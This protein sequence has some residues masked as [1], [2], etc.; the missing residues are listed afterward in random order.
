MF[1]Y[2]LVRAISFPTFV[3]GRMVELIQQKRRKEM[4]KRFAVALCFLALVLNCANADVMKEVGI[5]KI[6]KDIKARYPKEFTFNYEELLKKYSE[7]S[8]GKIFN[9]APDGFLQIVPVGP[10]EM[11]VVALPN[12][13]FL[14]VYHLEKGGVAYK[15]KVLQYDEIHGVNG[16]MFSKETGTGYDAGEYGP[17][18]EFG[19]ALEAAQQTGKVSLFIKRKYYSKKKKSASPKEKSKKIFLEIEKLGRFN[20][21]YPYKCKKSKFLADE[22]A[23]QIAEQLNGKRFARFDPLLALA[24]LSHGDPKHL[25]ALENVAQRCLPAKDQMEWNKPLRLSSERIH[26]SWDNGFRLVFLTEYFYATGDTRVIP[27]IQSLVYTVPTYHQN[28][29]GGFGHGGGNGS[30][31]GI[32]FGPSGGMNLT[33]VA[34]AHRMGL[35]VD[36]SAYSMYYNML[37]GRVNRQLAGKPDKLNFDSKKYY[38]VGYSH[39]LSGPKD[40]RHIGES[41][42]NT[43]TAILALDT[44][45][46]IEE[47]KAIALRMRDT[48]A[49]SP[50]LFTYIHATPGLGQFWATLAMSATDKTGE[51][52]KCQMEYRKYWL[53]YSRFPNKEWVYVYPKY[54]RN[55]LPVGGGWGGDGYLNMSK[56]QLGQ[57]LLMLSITNRNLCL[58]GNKKRNWMKPQVSVKETKTFLSSYHKKYA[59][60]AC[61]LKGKEL[62]EAVKLE[63]KKKHDDALF[64]YVA[65]HNSLEMLYDNY[66]ATPS[67]SKLKALL[68]K[69]KSKL[70][71]GSSKRLDYKLKQVEYALKK[72]YAQHGHERA[73]R[74][75]FDKTKAKLVG[76]LEEA[77]KKYKLPENYLESYAKSRGMKKKLN[78]E[79][80]D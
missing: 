39:I 15:G 25:P 6:V 10:L 65:L 57:C 26:G 22:L 14:I 16:K 63:K 44:M 50:Q 32:T 40:K 45:P 59:E 77:F 41:A 37:T 54:A 19:D 51:N 20:K 17:V 55:T 33:G 35:K 43:S 18:K 34:L 7:E 60:E 47:S 67:G 70:A 69:T 66:K 4:G 75:G 38:T 80:S 71:K 73:E 76:F 48:I 68:G 78:D 53:T 5:E 12:T 31:Y 21:T 1:F 30:Y 61:L 11:W 58:Q 49:P 52:T 2:E 46:A 24:L 56:V 3:R 29:F 79:S 13:K 8:P 64:A 27:T 28:A 62:A 23:D 36:E 72:S 42:F 74:E 9:K